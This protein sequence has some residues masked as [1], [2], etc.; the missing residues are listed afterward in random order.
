MF[1]IKRID[2]NALQPVKLPEPNQAEINI[3]ELE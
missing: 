3:V 1:S 2:G